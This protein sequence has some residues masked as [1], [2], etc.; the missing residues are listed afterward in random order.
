MLSIN[1][2]DK[3]SE[4]SYRRIF[5]VGVIP[6]LT[7]KRSRRAATGML[8]ALIGIA[9][10]FEAKPYNLTSTNYLAYVSL[11]LCYMPPSKPEVYMP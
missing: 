7:S 8:T 4:F 2:G 3:F 1:K 9:V 6:L 10:Y 11:L 5:Y